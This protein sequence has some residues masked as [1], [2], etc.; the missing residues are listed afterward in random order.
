MRKLFEFGI[1]VVSKLTNIFF[2]NSSTEVNELSK[3]S[4]RWS[5]ILFERTFTFDLI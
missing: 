4:T 1:L 2:L 5:D 3:M